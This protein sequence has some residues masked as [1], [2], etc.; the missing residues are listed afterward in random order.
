MSLAQAE[1]S[2]IAARERCARD[3][4]FWTFR[5]VK[6]RDEHDRNNPVKPFPD[7]AYLRWLINRFH[8]GPKLIYVAKSRQLAVSWALSAYGLWTCL[9]RPMSNVLLQSKKEQDAAKMIY[10]KSPLQARMSFMLA[11]L[12]SYMRGC[13]DEHGN[14]VDLDLDTYFANFASEGHLIFPNGSQAL[15][16]AQGPAQVESEVITLYLNDEASLQDEWASGQAAAQP[17]ID[18]DARGITVGTMRLPSDYGEEVKTCDRVR[19]DGVMRGVAEFKSTE[20]VYGIRLHYS[21]DPDKDPKTDK[22]QL[23]K[24]AQL[25]SGAYQGG[26]KGWRWQQH[27]EINP[28][29][30]GG[31]PVFPPLQDDRAYSRIVIRPIPLQQLI[32]ERWI[33]SSGLD[34]GKRNL[35]AWIIRGI[36][37][38]GMRAQVHELAAPGGE[39]GGIR[40]MCD[41]MKSHPLFKKLNGRIQADPSLWNEDQNQDGGGLVSKAA[42]FQRYGV[43]LLR[44]AAKGQQA[45]D[46]LVERLNGY[47]WEGWENKNFSPLYVIFD[48]C[49]QTIRQFKVL[50]F[51]EFSEGIRETRALKETIRDKD[52]DTFDA[53]KYDEVQWRE[54]P[55]YT[56]EV[57]EGTLAW[58]RAAYRR[59][60][61]KAPGDVFAGS[62]TP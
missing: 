28:E 14:W 42:L 62:V 6:T 38:T 13:M 15:A 59:E 51:D 52:N 8:T 37:P 44:A 31:E 33:F 27:M 41:T 10:R 45:D 54:Y 32:S 23:W 50:R 20:G 35:A 21:A 57:M 19:P 1:A 46:I 56:P 58:H 61:A 18:G 2:L 39:L 26:E 22:G 9:F 29:S 7:R 17:A 34:W 30:R 11:K 12:P 53:T 40:G 24:R 25:A 49:V 43:V 55:V 16:L 48:T 36:A 3:P 5:F 4:V 47:Y 60:H